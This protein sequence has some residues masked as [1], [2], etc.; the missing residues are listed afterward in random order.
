MDPSINCPVQSPVLQHTA[1]NGSIGGW[2]RS[3]LASPFR[4]VS[5]RLDTALDT[6]TESPFSLS[7]S[8]SLV[9]LLSL[10]SRIHAAHVHACACISCSLSTSSL[11]SRWEKASARPSKGAITYAQGGETRR[12]NERERK[13]G[14]PS[15]DRR[16]ETRSS[17]GG[18]HPKFNFGGSLPG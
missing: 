4:S 7:L 1:I 6:T 18:G 2:P 16:I 3:N 15:S 12:V 5:Y 10:L 14:P 17:R 13:G 11:F 9:L 8:L